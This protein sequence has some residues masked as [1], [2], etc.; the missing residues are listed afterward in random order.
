MVVTFFPGRGTVFEE[1][2]LDGQAEGQAAGLAEGQAAG[3]AEGQAKGVLRI[4]EVRGIPLSDEVREHITG[5]TDLARLDDWLDR[6]GTVE[7][8]ED[9]FSETPAATQETPTPE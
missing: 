6:A 5:C 9:L 1:A 7:R 8:A 2:F 4:L 3:L